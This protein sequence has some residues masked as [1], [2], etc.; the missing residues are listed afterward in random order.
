MNF[1]EAMSKVQQG[2]KAKIVGDQDSWYVYYEDNVLKQQ[3]K[4]L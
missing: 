2:F 4:M 3:Q 1:M